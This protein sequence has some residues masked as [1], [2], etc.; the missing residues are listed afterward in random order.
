MDFKTQ[1]ILD[2][3][4]FSVMYRINLKGGKFLDEGI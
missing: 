4:G 3:R 1:K 2:P